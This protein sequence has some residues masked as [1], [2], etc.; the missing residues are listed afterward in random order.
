MSYYHPNSVSNEVQTTE[1]HKF[2]QGNSSFDQDA[3]AI[4]S[5]RNSVNEKTVN[6]N[7]T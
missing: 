7:K 3:A 6:A 2:T 4:S 1:I 5:V